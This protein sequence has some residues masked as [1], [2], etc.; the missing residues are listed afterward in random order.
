MATTTK[1]MTTNTTIQQEKPWTSHPFKLISD[2]GL[3]ARS[4]VPRDHYVVKFTKDMALV[5]NL[6]LRGLNAAYNQCLSVTPGTQAAQD[7]L[8]FNQCVFEMLK[9]H[10]DMEEEELFPRLEKALNQPGA[11][12][13]NVAE[14]HDFHDGL[15][16]FH[17][18]VFNTEADDYDGPTL[19]AIIESFGSLVE[20]HLH[21]EI[22]PLYDLHVIESN[23]LKALW[24]DVEKDYQ[25]NFDKYRHV[26]LA[27]TCADNSF[28][29]DGQVTPF[30]G[31][32]VFAAYIVKF[33]LGR[34]FSGA[35]E[36][37]P[38]DFTG[39]PRLQQA[40]L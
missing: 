32:P 37:A 10:H 15:M 28:E 2:T 20:K 8:I 35:W 29:L 3:N 39:R 38:S 12:A 17:D 5:H 11:M 36:F 24:N 16:R 14:H 26:P 6:V 9:S 33:L 21:N 25:P 31:L 1:T 19:H 22:A 30:P 27:M 23:T 18:Y 4:D 34:K 40:S 7:F 13:N